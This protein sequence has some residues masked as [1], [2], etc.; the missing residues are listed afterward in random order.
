MIVLGISFSFFVQNV[1]QEKEIDSK[2]ELI[3]MNLLE[4]LKSNEAYL[5]KVKIDYRREMDYV[6]KLLKDS[7]TKEIIKEYP[8]NYSPFNPFLSAL[9]FSPSNSI[10]NSLVNDGSFNLI[11]P[12]TLKALIDDVYKFNYNN[13]LKNIGLE[14]EIAKE[15]V[16]NVSAII[17][18]YFG[19]D[20][21]ETRDIYVQFLQT[22]EGVEGD[23]ASIAVATAIISA[24]KSIP[25]KQSVAMTGSLSVRGEVLPIGGV[26]SKVEAAIDTGIK[27]I[28]VPKTNMQ[29]IVI[30]KERLNLVTIIPVTSINEVLK[31]ALD[32]KGKKQLKE[33]I[34]NGQAQKALKKTSK[35]KKN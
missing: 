14:R 17:M 23:S 9:D 20:I 11:K 21:K 26:T 33:M 2:R 16:K 7:L 30:D 18:R 3:M 31:Y 34:M 32:W 5:A 15:A 13:V 8:T 28:I 25:V 29:D 22:H 6:V 1:R 19:E 27:T 10:Y 24:L 4:E 35:T 12:P